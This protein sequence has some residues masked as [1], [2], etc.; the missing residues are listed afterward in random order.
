MRGGLLL[1]MV[2]AAAGGIPAALYPLASSPALF[3]LGIGMLILCGAITALIISVALTVY[4]PN[5]VRGFTIGLFIALAGLIGMG[6]APALLVAISSHMG[7][8][9]YLDAG[10]ACTSVS[11]SLVSVIA[12][13]VARRRA[14]ELPTGC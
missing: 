2:A 7:G 12:V 10:L 8:E 6:I 14:P 11:V 1:G 5:E 9:A 4:L 3:A 13:E